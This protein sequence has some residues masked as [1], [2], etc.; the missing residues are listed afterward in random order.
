[1]K[2]LVFRN[3]H[4]APYLASAV[5]IGIVLGTLERLYEPID[6][7]LFPRIGVGWTSFIALFLSIMVVVIIRRDCPHP[8]W[9]FAMG[10]AAAAVG[11]AT[12][13][14][15]DPFNVAPALTI[16]ELVVVLLEGS[17]LL[18]LVGGLLGLGLWKL[19]DALLGVP[20][21]Q[22]GSY[23]VNCAYTIL[24]LPEFRC[25]ECGKRFDETDIDTSPLPVS[26]AWRGVGMWA[27]GTLVLA[28]TAYLAFPPVVV[29]GLVRK[30]VNSDLAVSYLKFRPSASAKEL[31]GY[32][33]HEDARTRADAAF[34]LMLFPCCSSTELDSLRRLAVSD[35]DQ[36]VRG[37]AIQTIG[38]IAPDLLELMMPDL[39]KDPVP[40]N[41]WIALASSAP[42]GTGVPK[43]SDWVIA[44]LIA[45]LDDPDSA[46]RGF[47]RNRLAILTG[48]NFPFTPTALRDKRL[49]EQAVW[50]DWWNE[51]TA[52]K[53]RSANP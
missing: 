49:A 37:M 22:D 53:E 26:R 11:V 45:A 5:L 42:Y 6:R 20:L 47:V 30:G 25:P 12:N 14:L 27:A 7:F 24:G 43:P 39:L 19:R 41:R 17:V 33:D 13:V 4:H 8:R 31:G 36:L 18:G 23:C 15:F 16:G 3:H 32:L 35:P 1:M 40:S 9:R 10:S 2:Q 44:N 48:Q 38:T 50:S 21:I 28:G 46:T 29:Y 34:T 51:Q 52:A